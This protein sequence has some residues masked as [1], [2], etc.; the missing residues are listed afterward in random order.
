MA[1][2]TS[3]MLFA[4]GTMATL[5]L[6]R[7]GTPQP[8]E[9]M[10]APRSLFLGSDVQHFARWTVLPVLLFGIGTFFVG[11]GDFYLSA[12]VLGASFAALQM[13]IYYAARWGC[14]LVPNGTAQAVISVACGVLGIVALA[15][16][17][18]LPLLAESIPLTIR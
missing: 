6:I 9:K 7:I 5:I 16:C 18:V 4:L 13:A 10:G 17:L 2:L 8:Y 14:Q 11:V 3:T 1:K 12:F 15:G